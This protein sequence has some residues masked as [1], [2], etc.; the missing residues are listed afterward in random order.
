MY[1]LNKQSRTFLE[2]DY[3]LPDV[4][5]EQRIKQICDRAEEILGIKGFSDKF[6]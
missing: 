4:T 6:H 2:R 5:A 3:L 1:W